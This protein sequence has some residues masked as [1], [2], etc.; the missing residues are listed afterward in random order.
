MAKSKV[1]RRVLLWRAN[2][3]QLSVN[4]TR[5]CDIVHERVVWISNYELCVPELVK[6][7]E[8]VVEKYFRMTRG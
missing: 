7:E 8:V 4:P 3:R 6:E 2:W 5:I 1:A